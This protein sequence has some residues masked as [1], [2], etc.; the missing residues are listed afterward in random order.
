MLDMPDLHSMT[1]RHIKQIT[2][3]LYKLTKYLYLISLIINYKLLECVFIIKLLKLLYFDYLFIIR[4]TTIDKI[5]T[6]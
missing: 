2:V 4:M 5:I 3:S 1:D 6:L